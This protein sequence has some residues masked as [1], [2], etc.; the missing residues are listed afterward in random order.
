M[1]E[2]GTAA[3]DVPFQSISECVRIKTAASRSLNQRTK[4]DVLSAPSFL[5]VT[6][7][8]SAAVSMSL[9]PL[10]AR[11]PS[12]FAIRRLALLFGQPVRKWA[13]LMEIRSY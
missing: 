6:L 12:A 10:T 4:F 9:T 1:T 11:L 5:A 8:S 2:C 13:Q 7:L 3:F